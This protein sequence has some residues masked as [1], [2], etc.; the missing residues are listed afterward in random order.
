MLT[1]IQPV[2]TC[3]KT[4]METSEQCVKSVQK[5]TIIGKY[6]CALSWVFNSKLFSAKDFV[7]VECEAKLLLMRICD[8]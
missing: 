1:W 3:L 6:L 4:T 5:L 7:G 8:K 2:I